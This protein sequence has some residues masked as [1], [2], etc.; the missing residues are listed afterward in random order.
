MYVKQLWP[1]VDRA[2]LHP[3]PQVQRFPNTV[4]VDGKVFELKSWRWGFTCARC[5]KDFYLKAARVQEDGSLHCRGC[6]ATKVDL[7]WCPGCRKP[8]PVEKFAPLPLDPN[9][10]LAEAAALVEA[11]GERDDSRECH[12]CKRAASAPREYTL[13]CQHCGTS[14]ISK[15]RDAR[16]CPGSS[17]C[18]VAAM[19]AR[20][21]ETSSA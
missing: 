19:R 14:F 4:N 6:D 8:Q 2:R 18:R 21:R 5:R 13:N 10:P 11:L 3:H 1:R 20:Q 15:R 17:R 7:S 12:D 9:S 16:Y